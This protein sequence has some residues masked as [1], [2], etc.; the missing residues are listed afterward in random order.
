MADEQEW[1]FPTWDEVTDE[2]GQIME[3]MLPRNL[4]Y[5]ADTYLRWCYCLRLAKQISKEP[6]G[7]LAC[8]ML[9]AALFKTDVP[10]TDEDDGKITLPLDEWDDEPKY[11]RVKC[12]ACK[13]RTGVEVIYGYPSP[14]LGEASQ[15]GDV[16]LAGCVLDPEMP[17]RQCT[18]C[19]QQWGGDFGRYGRRPA[20]K[21]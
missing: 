18:A 9:A 13:Q 1:P 2:H 12:P 10:T 7:K 8:R 15:R 3:P 4:V 21:S 17:S 5:D 16:V 14:E 19:G 11:V 6:Y 20:Q